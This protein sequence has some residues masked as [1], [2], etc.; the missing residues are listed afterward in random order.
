MW[1]DNIEISIITRMSNNN[2]SFSKMLRGNQNNLRA[3]L[4][5]MGNNQGKG[6]MSIGMMIALVIVG[7][8]IVFYAYMTIK[9][10]YSFMNN[11]PMLIQN[12]VSGE[13]PSRIDSYRLPAPSDGRYGAEYTYSF[14]VYL[15]D[16]NFKGERTT[17]DSED[18]N[19]IDFRHIFHRGSG[20]VYQTVSEVSSRKNFPLLQSPGV[21]LYPNENKLNIRLNT[22]NSDRSTIYESCDV[23][24]IPVNKWVH[25]TLV[26]MGGSLDVYV[27]CNLKKRQKLAGVPKLNEG[28][29]YINNYGGFNGYLSRF[30]YYNYA[31]DPFE[32]DLICKMGP[33]ENTP[34]DDLGA[35]AGKGQSYLSPNYW[36]NYNYPVYNLE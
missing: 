3:N 36:F 7:L 26:L 12:T 32:L 34:M 21:W 2:N 8:L 6:G 27:N 25:I 1:N 33:S 19:Y 16:S 28:D 31:I 11:S 17:S 14:W 24:N 9:G 10:Y 29:L 35:A 20:D 5:V 23:G 13:T 18:E 30:R 15:K 22:Y 4:T